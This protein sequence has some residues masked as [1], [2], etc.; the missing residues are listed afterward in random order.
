M[1]NLSNDCRCGNCCPKPM[2]IEGRMNKVA[3]SI[4]LAVDNCHAFE[5]VFQLYNMLFDC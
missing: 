1:R 5:E 3:C 2:K 4:L